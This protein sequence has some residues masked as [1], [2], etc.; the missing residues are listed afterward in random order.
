MHQIRS[1]EAKTKT[2]KVYM[3]LSGRA[4][5]L[6]TLRNELRM[7]H[8]TLTSALSRLQDMGLVKQDDSGRFS[9]VPKEDREYH[10]MLRDQERYN[11]WVKKGHDNG[12]FQPNGTPKPRQPRRVVLSKQ[13]SIL[14]EL[15]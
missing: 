3:H 10:A 13:M 8:Q 6:Q 4:C 12:W 11:R 1:G 7:P 14:D 2:H 15:K 9:H 5:K